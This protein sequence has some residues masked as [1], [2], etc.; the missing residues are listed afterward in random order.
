MTLLNANGNV[1]VVTVRKA[2]MNL[3]SKYLFGNPTTEKE[4][5][6]NQNTLSFTNSLMTPTFQEKTW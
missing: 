6:D 3:S 4:Q 5:E 1:S 2:K